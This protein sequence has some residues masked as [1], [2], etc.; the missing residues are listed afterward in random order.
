MNDPPVIDSPEGVYF[1]L[2]DRL[3][4]Q[5]REITAWHVTARCRHRHAPQQVTMHE[6]THRTKGE[7]Y[8]GGTSQPEDV[9][10]CICPEQ[11][12]VCKRSA[13]FNTILEGL[14]ERVWE[15]IGSVASLTWQAE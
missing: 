6:H 15:G 7:L 8:V 13:Q 3:P 10:R 4:C 2:S 5:R 9:E 1:S 11:P 12:T 14:V